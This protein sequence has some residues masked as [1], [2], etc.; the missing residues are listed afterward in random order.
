[1][2]KRKKEKEKQEKS[3]QNFT[4]AEVADRFRVTASTVKNWRDR[5]LLAYFQAPGSRRI[6]YPADAI[7]V[8]EKQSTKNSAAIKPKGITRERP[9]V[10]PRPKADWRI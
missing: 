3:I 6:L 8:F 2:L 5:G 7:I 10:S 9:D 1:M 4:Q